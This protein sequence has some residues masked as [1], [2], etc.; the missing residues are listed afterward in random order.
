MNVSFQK[1]QETLTM[2]K[3]KTRRYHNDIVAQIWD[4]I[5]NRWIETVQT[6][7][8]THNSELRPKS[9]VWWQASYIHSSLHVCSTSRIVELD[10]PVKFDDA[11]FTSE[12]VTSRAV[13]TKVRQHLDP[14]YRR[15]RTSKRM[16][17]C[18][19]GG[20][21]R[22]KLERRRQLVCSNPKPIVHRR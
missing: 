2:P 8:Y 9:Q 18:P 16:E 20:N 10:A 11:Y 5:G 7:N 17:C 15:R 14:N 4:V 12:M 19:I 6:V 1:L 3:T 13:D 21:I 22:D